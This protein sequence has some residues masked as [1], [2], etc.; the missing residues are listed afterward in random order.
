MLRRRAA[1]ETEERL[2]SSCKILLPIMKFWKSALL[3]QSLVDA[4]AHVRRQK[5]LIES[6]ERDGLS[7]AAEFTTLKN[8]QTLVR[9]RLEN[10]DQLMRELH[11]PS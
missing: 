9:L 1:N 4:R 7:V 8:L 5:E 6:L 11:K 2:P 3:K 10:R